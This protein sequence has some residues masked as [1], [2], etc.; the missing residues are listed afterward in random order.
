MTLVYDNDTKE[1]FLDDREHFEAQV[2]KI[3]KVT[4]EEFPG[5]EIPSSC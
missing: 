4:F 1:E 3:G 2:K 5:G